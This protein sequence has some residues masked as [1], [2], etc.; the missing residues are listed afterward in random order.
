MKLFLKFLIWICLI[1]GGVAQAADDVTVTVDRR[2]G[3]SVDF[4][5]QYYRTLAYLQQ[6]YELPID[7]VSQLN[8]TVKIRISRTERDRL[9]AQFLPI[10]NS[11][12][13]STLPIPDELRLLHDEPELPLLVAP[14]IPAVEERYVPFPIEPV[15][16]RPFFDCDYCTCSWILGIALAATL[17]FGGLTACLG[18]VYTCP[19]GSDKWYSTMSCLSNGHEIIRE[20]CAIDCQTIP[21]N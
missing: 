16:Y 14:R 5:T 19:D 3:F 8:A 15:R 6:T 21:C 11:I 1:F 9:Q 20:D 12:L 7:L 13:D 4:L 10:F 18:D 17:F 2:V